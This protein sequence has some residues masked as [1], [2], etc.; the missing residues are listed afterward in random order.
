M[1]PF[2][3]SLKGKFLRAGGRLTR[4]LKIV[5]EAAPGLT[6][7]SVVLLLV[8][9]LLPVIALYLLKVMLDTIT[10]ALQ[11]ADPQAAFQQVATAIALAGGIALVTILVR[12][13][14]S[15]V[16]AA[17]SRLVVDHLFQKLH[18]RATSIDLEFYENAEYYDLFFRVKSEASHRLIVV[19][20]ATTGVVQSGLSLAGVIWLLFSIHWAVIPILLIALVPGMLVRMRYSRQLH[21]LSIDYTAEDRRSQYYDW[22]LTGKEHAKEIRIFNLSGTFQ[23][24]YNEARHLLRKLRLRIETQ[25]A[26]LDTMAQGAGTIAVFGSF[27]LIAYQTIMGMNTFGDLVL[28][29]QAFQ[30]GQGFL[31]DL[32]NGLTTLYENNLFLSSLYD[33]LDLQPK[34]VEASNPLPFPTTMRKGIRFENVD[35]Q[36]PHGNRLVLQAVNLEIGPG[37]VIAL[38]GENGSG[39]TTLIK[40]L[41]RLYEPTRGRV[42]IDGH[43]LREYAS[44]DL[45]KAIGVIFQDYAHYYLTARENI[46]FGDSAFPPN[47]A[48]IIAAAEKS[49]AHEVIKRLSKGYDTVLGT[50]FQNGEELSVGQWQKVALARAFLRDSQLIVL[51]EPT[52]ALDPKA[53]YEVFKTFRE[54]LD[55]RSAIL[56]SHRMS[57]VRMADRIFVLDKGRI[58][59]C[60]SHDDLMSRKGTYATLFETQAQYY[61]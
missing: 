19:L 51:D 22:V 9:G 45:R 58:V 57:T 6:I 55:G 28:F 15:V 35:F 50:L 42:T 30:R 38:V 46:H 17:H 5:W 34:I 36:Y 54:L 12:S 29:Y 53:E 31:Q 3:N 39:K 16:G 60:G 44:A 21:Q 52:S 32:L 1:I 7:A 61:R 37:E 18:E 24:R 43:D 26:W 8:S 25:R 10:V 56:I 20:N 41:C 40:L 27:G 13:V 11:A 48:A 4:A 33:F 2:I 47:E 23:M 49:G 59:E 14:Y